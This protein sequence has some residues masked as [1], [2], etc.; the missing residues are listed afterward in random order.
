MPDTHTRTR[1][2][3]LFEPMESR[4]CLTGIRRLEYQTASVHETCIR[5]LHQRRRAPKSFYPG[6]NVQL[7]SIDSAK[8]KEVR[9]EV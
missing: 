2:R 8:V 6:L 5:T 7:R 3:H 4:R 1:R 9:D